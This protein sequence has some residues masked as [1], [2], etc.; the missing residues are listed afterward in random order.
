MIIIL[1]TLWMLL[2]GLDQYNPSHLTKIIGLF[3]LMSNHYLLMRQLKRQSTDKVHNNKL[4]NTNLK[5]ATVKKLLLDS[6]TKTA[7][8]F[9]NVLYELYGG[10]SMGTSLEPVL[11]NIILTE[12]ENV[13]VKP[14]IET[15]V[16]L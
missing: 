9:D 12:F 6:S 10:V 4:I 3:L 5:K 13:I 14:L 16:L 15:K 2:K 7:S 8:S 1:K 11:A